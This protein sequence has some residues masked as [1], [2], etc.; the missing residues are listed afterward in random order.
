MSWGKE[1]SSLQ[2]QLPQQQQSKVNNNNNI[3]I[4]PNQNLTNV[5]TSQN[6]KS[7]RGGNVMRILQLD[8]ESLDSEL[9]ELIKDKFLHSFELFSIS[10]KIDLF[11][12]EI[13]AFVKLVF[14]SLSIGRSGTS[15]GL[16]LMNL[17]LRNESNVPLSFPNAGSA[18][19]LLLKQK[20]FYGL[21]TI[22]LPYLWERSQRYITFSQWSEANETDIK[23]KAWKLFQKIETFVLFVKIVHFIS[24]LGDGMYRGIIERVLK[25]RAVYVKPQISRFI[26]FELLHQQLLW[27]T[28]T[29]LLSTLL[30]I[31]QLSRII[32]LLKRIKFY[33]S[34]EKNDEEN[35][36]EKKIV[37]VFESCPS[38]GNSSPVM[39]HI[40]DCYCVYCYVCIQ[41][42]LLEANEND[43]KEKEISCLKCGKM[44]KNARWVRAIDVNKDEE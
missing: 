13:E 2:Q 39:P 1:F 24:F 40:G 36:Q 43:D 18:F 6:S 8:A 31:L 7:K 41:S 27:T 37:S 34:Q 22:G 5:L 44:I 15:P 11:K 30:P 35:F 12:P 21:L 16:T 17:R 33:N 32:K 19:P 29:D 28:I 9:I 20:I 25:I 3:N 23:F 38:C 26:S 4:Q 14:Y 42:L 10:D